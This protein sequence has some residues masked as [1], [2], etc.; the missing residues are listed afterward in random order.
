[1]VFIDADFAAAR[2]RGTCRDAAAF[3]GTEAAALA[4]EQRYHAAG[5]EYLAQRSRRRQLLRVGASFR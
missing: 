2:E 3:G 4:Y 1:M 5:R